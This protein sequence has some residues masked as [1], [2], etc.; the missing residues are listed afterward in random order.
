MIGTLFERP[1]TLIWRSTSLLRCWFALTLSFVSLMPDCAQAGQNLVIDQAWVRSSLG[2]QTLDLVKRRPEQRFDGV[3]KLEPSSGTTWV[4]LK[5][6]PG[7]VAST[8]PPTLLLRVRP[9]SL[10]RVVVHVDPTAPTG[11]N[12][13]GRTHPDKALMRAS[14]A[15]IFELPPFYKS[16]N[17]WLE[18]RSSAPQI[19]SFEVLELRDLRQAES[20]EVF[21]SSALLGGMTLLALWALLLCVTEQTALQRAYLANL[22]ASWL[23]AFFSTSAAWIVMGDALAPALQ[24]SLARLFQVLLPFTILFFVFLLLRTELVLTR[25]A[26]HLMHGLLLASFMAIMLFGLDERELAMRVASTVLFVGTLSAGLI[27]HLMRTQPTD[28]DAERGIVPRTLLLVFIWGLAMTV[29]L[30][31]AP[32]LD[33]LTRH[34]PEALYLSLYNVVYNGIFLLFILQ[35][36][37]HRLRHFS[38]RARSDQAL[39]QSEA[40]LHRREAQLQSAHRSDVE[41]MLS[42]LAHELRSPLATIRMQLSASELPR[43][44]SVRID[45]Q[46]QNMGDLIDRSQQANSIDAMAAALELRAFQLWPLIEVVCL[47][48][49]TPERIDLRSD[50]S[51]A[52]ALTDEFVL[53]IV[54]KNLVENALK[55]SPRRSRVTVTLSRDQQSGA[56][57]ID[58]ANEPGAA[59]FPDPEKVFGKYYRSAGAHGQSGSGLGLFVCKRLMDKLGGRVG[60]ESDS[61]LVRFRLELPSARSSQSIPV[62]MPA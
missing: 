49:Q 26:C 31:V 34:A 42:M 47:R 12:P 27:T 35:L 56:L 16:T 3:L 15:L 45:Q 21:W 10:D 14:N 22:M 38:Q 36:R 5:V 58:V 62:E 40:L 29:G 18:I 48:M 8:N 24:E 25:W 2:D 51:D 33:V 9:L 13:P 50:V 20:E 30:S 39:A 52:I 7:V 54:L 6:D 46:L 41:L 61:V 53:R 23:T 4:R 19:A 55:Y 17:L 57:L 43:D 11:Q 28:P 59:G 1:Y 60:L 32:G 44:L 37:T